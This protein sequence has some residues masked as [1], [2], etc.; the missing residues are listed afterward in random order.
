MTTS[1]EFAELVRD[2]GSIARRR[3]LTVPAYR[4]PP[5]YGA[6]RTVR[7]R[8]D[9]GAVVAVRLRDSTLAEVAEDIVAGLVAVNHPRSVVN[10]GSLVVAEL[11]AELLAE[12]LEGREPAQEARTAA[13]EAEPAPSLPDFDGATYERDRDHA[14]LGA[15]LRRV[16]DALADGEWWTLRGLAERTGDPEASVSAR[17][18]DLRKGK[19][20]GYTVI[21]EPIRRGLWRYRLEA[22]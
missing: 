6:R 3:G 16:A 7:W 1:L 15:Q 14:R 9:G 11:H 21:A 22:E 13:P 5:A 10:P 8:A 18:R 17:L 12:L 19:F 4:S 2:L 20:G